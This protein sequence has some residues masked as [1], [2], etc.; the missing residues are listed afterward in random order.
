MIRVLGRAG[1]INVRKVLWTL[2][3]IG[4]AYVRED[5]GAETHPTTDPVLLAINPKAL[6]P[7]LIDG[8]AVLTESNTI[9]RYLAARHGRHDLLPIDPVGR[10][11]VEELMDW[12]A[13][14]FNNAW[15]YAFLSLVRRNAAA[16]DPDQLHASL[17][18]WTSM[19]SL[20]DARLQSLGPHLCGATFTVADIV[21]G[22]S[23]NR[24]LRA[25]IEQ[26]AFAAV[27]AYYGRLLQR[28][29]G[30]RYMG[31]GAD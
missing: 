17:R 22:L 8:D 12:Q 5:W 9:I 13:T 14:E 28:P 11:H 21:I 7:V 1:S 31:D 27:A 29:A 3:E 19:L 4:V 18:A 16:D 25:P 15:R 23:V 20:L 6:V 26:P 2:D 30:S 10:A 24:W